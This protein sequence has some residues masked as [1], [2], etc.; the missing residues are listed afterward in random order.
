MRYCVINGCEKPAYGNWLCQAH[1]A[2]KRKYGDATV[3]FQPRHGHAT[4]SLSPEYR[5]WMAMNS[6]CSNKN[7]HAYDRYG[8]RGIKVCQRWKRSFPNFLEDM[9]HRPSSKHS[10]DRIDV[11][12]NYE[13]DNCRWATDSIQGTNKRNNL[14]HPG[15]YRVQNPRSVSWQARLVVD[16]VRVLNKLFKTFDEALAARKEAEQKWNI[17]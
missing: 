7:G 13:P 14:E 12:G 3:V 15:V 11:N 9:G 8:G 1:Y 4:G 6:R 10:L 5:A 17:N 16:N 2:K